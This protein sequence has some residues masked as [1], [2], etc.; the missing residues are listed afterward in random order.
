VVGEESRPPYDRPPL[1][2]QVLAGDWA[3]EQTQ[4]RDGASLDELGAEWR[5]GTRAVGLDPAARAVDLDTGERL[6]YDGLVIATGAAPRRLPGT[7]DLTGVYV[8]RTLDDC[9]AIGAEL[10]REPKVVVVGA[11]F[12]GAEVAATCRG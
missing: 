12:I 3:P 8:L 10:E 7:D 6:A 11:G 9:L 2:K 4:L 1:S 5:L